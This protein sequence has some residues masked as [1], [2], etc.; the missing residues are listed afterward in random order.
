MFNSYVTNYQRVNGGFPKWGIPKSPWVSISDWSNDLDDLGLVLF[1]KTSIWNKEQ[2]T[3][4]FVFN[5]QRK[6]FSSIS[7]N[8]ISRYHETKNGHGNIDQTMLY[9]PILGDETSN[10]AQPLQSLGPTERNT[11]SRQSE[12]F[13]MTV[14]PRKKLTVIAGQV[15]ELGLNFQWWNVVDQFV[16]WTGCGSR[17]FGWQIRWFGAFCGLKITKSNHHLYHLFHWMSWGIPTLGIQTWLVND[18]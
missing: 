17:T 12:C 14:P 5:I 6:P 15:S 13:A 11:H 7:T 1:E 8:K 9:R 16:S 10:A 2:W 4:P 18:G 3:W